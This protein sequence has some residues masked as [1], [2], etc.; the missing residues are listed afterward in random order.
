MLK[1][2]LSNK[3]KKLVGPLKVENMRDKYDYVYSGKSIDSE[4]EFLANFDQDAVQGI[5]SDKNFFRVRS[6]RIK[7]FV[8]GRVKNSFSFWQKILASQ[9][10]LDKI[11][12]GY[13]FLFSQRLSRQNS[14]TTGRQL[15]SKI[16]GRESVAKLPFQRWLY[17]QFRS[18]VGYHHVDICPQHQTY[19]CVHRTTIWT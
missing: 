14:K 8:Q 2:F 7:I 18:E 6:R 5:N 12:Y 19:L 3:T 11:A 16:W 9:K 4:E 17:I 13:K 15:L 1:N 10:V